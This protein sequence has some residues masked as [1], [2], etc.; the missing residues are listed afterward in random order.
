MHGHHGFGENSEQKLLHELERRKGPEPR[1]PLA[2]VEPIARALVSYLRGARGVRRVVVAGSYRRRKE[3]VR[4]LDL[5]VTA[6]DPAVATGRLLSFQDVDEMLA[7]SGAQH[8]RAQ[9]GAAC[10]AQAQ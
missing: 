2:E 1:L 9:A 8:C 4:D 7:H 6:S 5:L 10:W 3:S